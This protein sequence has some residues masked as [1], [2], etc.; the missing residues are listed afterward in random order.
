ML[1]RLWKS[2]K[3]VVFWSYRRGSWQ[4]DLICV[5]ILAFIFGT[6]HSFFNDR[7]GAPTTRA[8]EWLADAGADSVFW[9][10]ASAVE[11]EDQ[12][13]VEQELQRLV[14]RRSGKNLRVTKIER[15]AGPE[16]DLNAYL[17]YARP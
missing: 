13:E 7:P 3:P 2:L 17:V 5:A 8:I 12:S 10:Q 4:Y 16:G 9:V 11:A 6:P 15:S 14:A 1:N